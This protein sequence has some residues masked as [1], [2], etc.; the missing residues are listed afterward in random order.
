MKEESF[1]KLAVYQRAKVVAVEVCR[2]IS[3]S[4]N[5]GLR[6]QMIRSAISIPSNLAEGAERAGKAEFRQFISYAKGSAGELRCQISIAQELGEIKESVAER[7]IT[8]LTEISRMLHGLIKSL[9]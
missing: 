8:E 6:D 4:R 1:E 3:N 9:K 2:E 7:L 5:F